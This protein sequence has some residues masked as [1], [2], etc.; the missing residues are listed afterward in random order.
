MELSVVILAAGK[1]TRMKSVLPK[2]MQPLASRPLLSH[3]L[4]S[5]A[6][7][8]STRTLVVYGHGGE[9]VREAFPDPRLGWALQAEQKGTG[10]AV[11]MALPQLPAEGKTLIL[12]GDVPLTGLPTLNRLL[13]LVKD[14]HAS[15]IRGIFAVTQMLIGQEIMDRR[16][17]RIAGIAR[18][19]LKSGPA[20]CVAGADLNREFR[21]EIHERL[22]HLNYRHL[23]CGQSE[24][25]GQ[26]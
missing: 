10:H 26:P 2:V 4:Q 8:H 9:Q 3:V 12:Y 22:P 16:A 18:A 15:K 23:R 5:A 17:R 20:R 19:K 11:M 6:E 14:E 21:C 1:G 24:S 7:L 13:D 25:R